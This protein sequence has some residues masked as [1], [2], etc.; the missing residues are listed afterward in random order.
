MFVNIIDFKKMTIAFNL[1]KLYELFYLKSV[2][3]ILKYGFPLLLNTSP[4]IKPY[5][6]VLTTPYK[7]DFYYV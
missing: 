7:I 4:V 2:F 3:V 1:N 5:M 6:Y